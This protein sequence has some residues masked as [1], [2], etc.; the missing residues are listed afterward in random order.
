MNYSLIAHLL[1]K[2]ERY[3]RVHP[4]LILLNLD[5]WKAVGSP[6][7]AR[8]KNISCLLYTSDAADE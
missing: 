3:Y 5:H 6:T 7:F 4:Q 1:D 2:K 8:A